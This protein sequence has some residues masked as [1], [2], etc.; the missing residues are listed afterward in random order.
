MERDVRCDHLNIMTIDFS[1]TRWHEITSIIDHVLE[2]PEDKQLD[3]L[4]SLCDKNKSLYEEIEAL[5]LAEKNALTFLSRPAAELVTSLMSITGDTVAGGSFAQNLEGLDI[6]SYTLCEELGRGGMGVVYRA[7]RREGEFEQQVAIKLLSHYDNN[8]N[9][10]IDRFK[11]E[12][13]LLAS[14]I[15]PNIAQ[16]YDAG[17]TAEGQPYF[18]MEY[19]SG[20]PFNEYC[21]KNNLSVDARLRLL[22]Q[23][24]DAL[25]YAHSH[26]IVHRDIKHSNI[27]VTEQGHVKLLD[28]GIAKLLSESEPDNLTRTGENIMTPGFAAPEQLQNRTITIATDIYQLGLVA[29]ELLTNRQVFRDRAASLAELVKMICEEDPSLPSSVISRKAIFQTSTKA[30]KSDSIVQSLSE[31]EIKR[32]GKKLKGDVDAIILKML[33]NRPE[34]RYVSMLAVKDDIEA[35]FEKRPIAAQNASLVYQG[36]KFVTRHWRSLS[37]VTMFIMLLAVYAVTV[38]YQA[39]EISRA[40]KVSQ[41]ETEKANKVSDFLVSVFKAADPTVAGLESVTAQTL[42]ERGEERIEQELAQFPEI[43]AHM[44]SLFGEIYFSQSKLDNSTSFV[45]RSLQ[46]QRNFPEKN[47]KSLA[48]TLTLLASVYT[49]SGKYKDAEPLFEES[50]GIYKK[51]LSKD[52]LSQSVAYAE[53]LALYGEFKYYTADYDEAKKYL[54]EAIDILSPLA[55]GQHEEL[56]T[57]LNNLAVLQ[58]TEGKFDSAKKNMQQAIEIQKNILG[59]EH[60]YYAVHLTN[61]AIMLTDMELLDDAER[62][63]QQALELQTQILKSNHIDIAETYRTLGVIFHRR[64]QLE[65]AERYIREAIAI[66]SR[67]VSDHTMPTA[68]DYMWLGAVLQDLQKYQEADVFYRDMIK[69]F[70]E[71][72]NSNDTIGRA[73][74]QIASLAFAQDNI[75]K[76]EKTYAEALR[77]MADGGMR[78]TFAQV[79]YGRVLLAQD[80]ADEA[81]FLVRLA[82]QK[83]SEKF[84]AKHS[85]IAEVQVLLGLILHQQEKNSEALSLLQKG[86]KELAGRELFKYGNQ[87]QLLKQGQIALAILSANP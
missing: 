41:L 83:R 80:K 76:A 33:R 5:L 28:F 72:T 17:L 1:A 55:N 52:E 46:K 31:L 24:I 60:S 53:T 35:Y 14:L 66:R 47:E 70:R 21:Q 75:E 57:A 34:D 61:F 56:A 73:L 50:L 9:S 67:A 51:L 18:V 10:L 69:I 71:K 22:Q 19:V 32:L 63:A 30:K 64:G 49:Y 48:D 3:Y 36:K 12:Q 82:L 8:K 45:E 74:C 58:H 42:L 79:G 25:S 54:V 29:Y 4:K 39:D 15:H 84:P 86:V 65:K 77:I 6:G 20:Q 62:L 23:V 68:I 81:E 59:E 78:K 87:H 13:R 85:M 26:L 7:E 40:L 43:Q 11:R 37:A 16:L 27:L 44:L 2:Q 38:T